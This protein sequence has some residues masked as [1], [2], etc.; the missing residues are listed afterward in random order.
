M[1]SRKSFG[2]IKTSFKKEMVHHSSDQ[3]TWKGFL[4]F[5][6]NVIN[7]SI[8][9]L[10]RIVLK[11]VK[12]LVRNRDYLHENDIS[13]MDS[14]NF[15]DRLLMASVNTGIITLMNYVLFMSMI[16]D[17]LRMIWVCSITL[18]IEIS[19]LLLFNFISKSFNQ[20]KLAKKIAMKSSIF[21]GTSI[22]L[23][24]MTFLFLTQIN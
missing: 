15:N 22:G 7:L 2:S 18:C 24:V 14:F 1:Q 6:I 16:S 5:Q 17:I 20:I 13:G 4:I 12:S 8:M 9:A 19:T 23:I 11:L 21:L 10:T 3:L